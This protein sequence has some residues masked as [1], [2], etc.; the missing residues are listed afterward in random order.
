[1]LPGTLGKWGQPGWGGVEE[2]PG[3]PNREQDKQLTAIREGDN[4]IM[5]REEGSGVTK[6]T[7][8]A[9]SEDYLM[10]YEL[11]I[12]PL[13]VHADIIDIIKPSCTMISLS[14]F[15]N[16]FRRINHMAINH[17]HSSSDVRHHHV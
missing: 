6:R 15:I 5:E 12:C 14:C 17:L 1:M 9:Q 10:F 4:S 11:C 13:S 2:G 8:H 16:C 3:P 7:H